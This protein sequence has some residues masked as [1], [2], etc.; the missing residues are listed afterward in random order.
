MDDDPISLISSDFNPTEPGFQD[1]DIVLLTTDAVFFYAHIPTLLRES[2]NRFGNL[3]DEKSIG[4][5]SAH[6]EGTGTYRTGSPMLK[7]AI[8]DYPSDVM[9]LVLSTVYKRASAEI[10]APSIATLQK[11][12][13]ALASLGYCPRNML[14]PGSELFTRALETAEI[15][16]LPVYAL[17]A[18][19]S[20]EP[21]AVAV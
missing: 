20:L 11:S 6:R 10:L 8:C 16:P 15:D 18:Q 12:F 3:I 1:A 4:D 9:E 17:A 5:D 13:T 7:L 19:H 2:S 14:T 21:L